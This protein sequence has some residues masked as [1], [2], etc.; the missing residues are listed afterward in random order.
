MH[1]HANTQPWL[2]AHTHTHV[3]TNI[4]W[5]CHILHA[6]LP[7]STDE[8]LD[9]NKTPGHDKDKWSGG[10][11]DLLK[12]G[13]KTILKEI[14]TLVFCR[15]TYWGWSAAK[16]VK[17]AP[18]SHSYI[19]KRAKVKC[20]EVKEENYKNE[21]LFSNLWVGFI[22]KWKFIPMSL[23]STHNEVK[24]SGS[25]GNNPPTHQSIHTHS[26]CSL[27][28]P[29]PTVI[30]IPLPVPLPMPIV[31]WCHEETRKAALALEE[32][33][34]IER[35]MTVIRSCWQRRSRSC[36]CLDECTDGFDE[37]DVCL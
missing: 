25:G 4:Y 5:I 17:N 16:Y 7:D 21:S 14:D 23:F 15:E 28:L 26:T 9:R 35:Q 30:S 3:A 8:D 13:Y 22:R 1:A 32:L 29:V 24:R 2:K 34:G 18:R 11:P 20:P 10:E 33:P 31:R 12:R 6:W 27:H 36:W 37:A 19:L